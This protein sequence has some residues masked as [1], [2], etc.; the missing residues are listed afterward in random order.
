MDI[1]FQ[2]LILA[3]AEQDLNCKHLKT[4]LAIRYL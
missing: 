2:H 4:T 3:L 1:N